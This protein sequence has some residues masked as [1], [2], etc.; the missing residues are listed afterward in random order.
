MAKAIATYLLRDQL[1]NPQIASCRARH[2]QPGLK[3]AYYEKANVKTAALEA[4]DKLKPSAEE[5]R[6]EA[7]TSLSAS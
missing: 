1:T 4:F 2:R 6:R 7:P 5:D 3:F